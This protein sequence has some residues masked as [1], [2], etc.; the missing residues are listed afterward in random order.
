METP[1]NPE[2]SE[3]IEKLSK[4]YAENAMT[5]YEEKV[6]LSFIKYYDSKGT[7]TSSQMNLASRILEN[8]TEDA[9]KTRKEWL[10]SFDE[11]KKEILFMVASYYRSSGQ[12]F[13]ALSRQVLGDK[14]FIPNEKTYR[15]LCENKYAKKVV[16]E[17]RREPKYE[18]GSL[19]Y[20]KSTAPHNHQ[21]SLGRGAI[22]L[23]ANAE[24]ITSAVAGGKKYL[25][26]PIG[27][28]HGIVIEERWLKKRR[29]KTP[30]VACADDEVP[31]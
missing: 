25:V 9:V 1:P 27:E 12:Y 4:A 10:D 18:I 11:E 6:C 15:K 13:K 21:K 5:E 20:P 30:E 24:P 22:V 26:L 2:V 14:D 3:T 28:P 7:L 17:H 19:V 29:S 16:S 8:Y 23:R 31:F